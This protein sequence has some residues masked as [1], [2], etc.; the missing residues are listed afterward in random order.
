MAVQKLKLPHCMNIHSSLWIRIRMLC[1][2]LPI[3]N[4]ERCVVFGKSG[5]LKF[6]N[7]I[8]EVIFACSGKWIVS[9]QCCQEKLIFLYFLWDVFWWVF[10]LSY[11]RV[12]EAN[13]KDRF[14][15]YSEAQ[16]CM[17]EGTVPIHWC[18]WNWNTINSVS[19]WSRV[20]PKRVIIAW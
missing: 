19:P 1:W 9:G 3:Q 20:L 4:A 6:W 15:T 14:Q 5:K 16:Y 18:P 12:V 10:F 2:Y 17:G 11:F 7:Y 13:Y 8:I